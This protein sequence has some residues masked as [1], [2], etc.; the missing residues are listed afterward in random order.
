MKAIKLIFKGILALVVLVFAI[1]IYGA[2]TMTDE[3]KAAAASRREA[4][5]EAKTEAKATL[6]TVAKA[7]MAAPK[8]P[9]AQAVSFELLETVNL[10]SG[11]RYG[12]ILIAEGTPT[13][14]IE[15]TAQKAAKLHRLT[16]TDVYC[17][18][19]ALKANFTASIAE[20]NPG[21]ID[22]CYIARLEGAHFKV[23]SGSGL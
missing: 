8:V 19:L 7:P 10:M 20:A 11:G 23:T 4:K 14:I 6:A 3:E 22:R 15:L 1:G 21:E 9:A 2:A 13:A 18:R 5:A 17:S 12:A 16:E